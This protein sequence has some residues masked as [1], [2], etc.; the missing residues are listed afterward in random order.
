MAVV[1]DG[2]TRV[3]VVWDGATWVA[4]VWDGA[5]R[6]AVVWDGATRV[7]VVTRKSLTG[8]GSTCPSVREYDATVFTTGDSVTVDA[9]GWGLEV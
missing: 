9:L 2:A 8:S 3:A 7:A 5:T 1:W 6:V 4:V